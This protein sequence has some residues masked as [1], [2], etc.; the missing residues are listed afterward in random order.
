MT[1]N[2]D[3][4]A[5]AA[6]DHDFY[7]WDFSYV[8][9][10]M[11]ESNPAWDYPVRAKSGVPKSVSLL[12]VGTGGGEL[13]ATF[14]PF[15]A[16]THATETYGANIPIAEQTLT[17]LGVNVQG[18]DD[19]Y[20]LPY[21][22]AKFDLILNR[23]SYVAVPETARVLK[24]GG[25]FITQQVGGANNVRL[26]DLLT[27]KTPPVKWDLG[28]AVR[29]LEDAGFE[30]VDEQEAY[31]ET[32]FY[33]IG[34]VVFYLRVIV[35]QIDDFSVEKYETQLRDIHAMIERDGKLTTTAH[36]FLIDAVKR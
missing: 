34:A 30:I 5:Q 11:V 16:D 23:H 17:P 29:L 20:K 2:F 8:C 25:R 28:E 19:V 35:W 32:I 33:D 21:D 14:A 27:G 13:F 3:A 1:S 36:R 15:P 4:L 10:R 24:S 31:P 6:L 7:G 26:N 12:D 9:G 22:D 18:V